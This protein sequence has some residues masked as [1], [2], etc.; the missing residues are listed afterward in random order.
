MSKSKRRKTHIITDHAVVRFMER[1]HN[2]NFAPYR[3]EMMSPELLQAIRNGL[4]EFEQGDMLFKIVAGRV[5]TVV[6][7]LPWWKR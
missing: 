6:P 2:F 1:K 3:E 5:V 4:I 7:I